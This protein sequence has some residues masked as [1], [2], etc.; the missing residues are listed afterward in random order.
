MF[1]TYLGLGPRPP[2]RFSPVGDKERCASVM[3]SRNLWQ[4]LTRL[5]AATSLSMEG[6]KEGR[7]QVRSQV[8]WTRG[9]RQG[10]TWTAGGRQSLGEAGTL[11]LPGAWL[12][13]LHPVH[14]QPANTPAH[15]ALLPLALMVTLL[16]PDAHRWEP[17]PTVALSPGL[18]AS[19]DVGPAGRMGPGVS[20]ALGPGLRPGS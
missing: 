4:T 13:L 2:D 6:G 5:P 20:P 9:R 14:R 19:V 15:G 3:N 16:R 7:A 10:G 18:Q 1:E 12:Q 11:T 17:V 8:V